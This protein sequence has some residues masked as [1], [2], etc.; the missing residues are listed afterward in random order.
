V[1]LEEDDVVDEEAAEDRSSFIDDERLAFPDLRDELS[2]GPTTSPP[3][4]CGAI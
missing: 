3:D 2:R 1:R 4:V